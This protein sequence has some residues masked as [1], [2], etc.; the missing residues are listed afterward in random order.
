MFYTQL[1]E[2]RL[3]ENPAIH[4]FPSM[5]L[6]KVY[7]K[8]VINVN[9]YPALV[10]QAKTIE[11]TIEGVTIEWTKIYPDCVL[12]FLYLGSLRLDTDILFTILP[13]LILL[14]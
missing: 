9:N 10:E 4:L 1:G 13:F 14:S 3:S 5:E 6:L 2:L 11:A 12:D 8:C 7:K